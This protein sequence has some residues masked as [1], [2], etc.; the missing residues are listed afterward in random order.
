MKKTSPCS[1][2]PPS[3][4]APTACT[5]GSHHGA[6]DSTIWFCIPD[7]PPQGE[8]L[9][10]HGGDGEVKPVGPSLRRQRQST[11]KSAPCAMVGAAAHLSRRHEN[12][13]GAEKPPRG[14]G[15]NV[16]N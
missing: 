14:K 15:N 6:I 1:A 9:H 7:A 3:C 4:R 11:D 16:G 13:S 5:R 8:R 10:L 2:P 12:G